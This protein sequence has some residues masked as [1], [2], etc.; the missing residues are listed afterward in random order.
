M[1]MQWMEKVFNPY[2][3]VTSNHNDEIQETILP[4]DHTKLKSLE[5]KQKT[6]RIETIQV[7]TTRSPQ[8]LKVT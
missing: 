2:R 7:D 8:A 1:I 4:G 3:R 6:K 5:S